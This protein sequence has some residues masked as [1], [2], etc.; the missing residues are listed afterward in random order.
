MFS[1][2]ASAEIEN[3]C[4]QQC[5][6]MEGMEDLGESSVPICTYCLTHSS[7]LAAVVI[8]GFWSV[9]IFGEKSRKSRKF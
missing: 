5:L 7:T 1:R 3:S 6:K 8:N 2:I 9:D 4:D